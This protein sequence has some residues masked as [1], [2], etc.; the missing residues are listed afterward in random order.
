MENNHQPPTVLSTDK[1]AVFTGRAFQL[2][3]REHDIIHVLKQLLR[4]HRR[5]WNRPL[6]DRGGELL[7][8]NV[9]ASRATRAG[10]ERLDEVMP[11]YNESPARG[12][13]SAKRV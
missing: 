8:M 2:K 6:F 4:G 11:G 5:S 3:L 10:S 9:R 7:A 12:S 1:D 13:F